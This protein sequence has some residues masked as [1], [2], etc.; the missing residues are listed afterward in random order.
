MLPWAVTIPK[1]E[2]MVKFGWLICPDYPMVSMTVQAASRAFNEL[3]EAARVEGL[4]FYIFHRL[5]LPMSRNTI[6]SLAIF[7]FYGVEWPYT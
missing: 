2:M 7:Q 5:I 1:Y 6:S 4:D 3:I